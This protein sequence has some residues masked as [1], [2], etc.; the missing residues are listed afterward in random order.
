MSRQTKIQPEETTVNAEGV[1][2]GQPIT[3]LDHIPSDPPEMTVADDPFRGLLDGVDPMQDRASK[4]PEDIQAILDENG[5]GEDGIS[6]RC[7]LKDITGGGNT[8]TAAFIDSFVNQ[9]PDYTYVAQQFGPGDYMYVF[10]W[11]GRDEDGKRKTYSKTVRFRISERY[12]D[13][14]EE[15]LMKRMQEKAVKKRH[16]I[17]SAKLKAAMESGIDSSFDTETPR[18]SS[19]TVMEFLKR[20]AAVNQMM[21]I[22]PSHEEKR[23]GIDWE[24]VLRAAVPLIPPLLVYMSEKSKGSGE[25]TM[26]IMETIISMQQRNAD[27]TIQLLGKQQGPSTGSEMMKEVMGMVM[28]AV[29]LKSALSDKEETVVDK[30]FAT[31][32]GVLPMLM[33]M[34]T[35]RGVASGPQAELA[36][37]YIQNDPAMSELK[38]PAIRAE[39]VRRFD[40]TIGWEQ[41]DAL[42]RLAEM[43]REEGTCPRIANQQ[44][45]QGDPRNAPE[46]D[47]VEEDETI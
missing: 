13:L 22:T 3:D 2:I 42:L 37:R 26:R 41:T 36:K 29:D 16:I 9:V 18:D 24:G 8:A 33:M 46:V 5:L 38:N 12:Q 44:Y 27:Q 47:T 35:N 28:Q 15:H 21:N 14:Y 1:R 34:S 25:S 7:M 45:P 4:I 40:S 11:V 32:Q 10:T 30:I 17:R 39:V 31:V 43:P 23:G 20:H 19:E 6:Y